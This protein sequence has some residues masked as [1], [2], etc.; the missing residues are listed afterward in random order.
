MGGGDPTHFAADNLDDEDEED[1]EEEEMGACM[2][3]KRVQFTPHPPTEIPHPWTTTTAYAWNFAG[4]DDT[5]E[6]ASTHD[7]GAT[8]T[9]GADRADDASKPLAG[10][11]FG[12][13]IKITQDALG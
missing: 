8:E 4:S 7:G 6:D 9:N 2:P 10:G 13:A 5:G 3:P 12:L 11:S 1:E